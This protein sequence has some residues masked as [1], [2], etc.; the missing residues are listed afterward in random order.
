MKAMA[1][2]FVIVLVVGMAIG[3]WLRGTVEKE[4][5]QVLPNT[6]NII[7]VTAYSPDPRQTDSTPFTMASGKKA[8]VNDL[9]NLRYVAVSRDLK[10]KLK[11]NYG[12]RI[13]I[14]VEM[15]L[16]VQDVMDR[17]V[18]STVDL[19]TRSRRQAIGWGVKKGMIKEVKR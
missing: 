6:G 5:V 13:V 18:R 19:F 10:K 11:L 7:R 8:T 9:Y 17:K 4:K 2:V 16:E 12:D 3:Y 14:L 15:E 1:M